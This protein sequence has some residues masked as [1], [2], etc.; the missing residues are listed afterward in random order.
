MSTKPIVSYFKSG[1]PTLRY[2]WIERLTEINIINTKS[3]TDEFIDVCIKNKHRLFLHVNITGMGGSVFEPSIKSPRTIFLALAKLICLG[4][5]QKQILV[6]VNPVLPNE[7]GLRALELLLRVFTEF[8]LL[9]LRTVRLNQLYYKYAEDKKPDYLKN[10]G[11]EKFMIANDNINKRPSTKGIM[12]YLTKTESFIRDYYKLLSKYEAIIS[13]DKGTE[14]LIGVRELQ[15]LGYNVNWTSENG[16]ISRI[17]EYENNSKYK[18]IVNI[19]S[20]KHAIRCANR[21]CL[22]PWKY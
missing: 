17:I 16:T 4:F 5:N 6:I 20:N 10:P 14:Q 18:P 15:A 21:C 22:C 19:I 12:K 13:V 9:R 11:K 8:K 3:I 1:D 2:D 7:N